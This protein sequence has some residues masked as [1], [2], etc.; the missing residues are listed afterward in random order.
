MKY[1]VNKGNH[2]ANLTLDRLQ[3]FTTKWDGT[4]N[5]N[6]N[7]WYEDDDIA[8]SGWNKLGGVS[9]FF[10]I[11][12]RSARL[13]FQP[14]DNLGEFTMAGYVYSNGIR[15]ENVIPI[16]IY[17]DKDYK[18]SIEYSDDRRSWDF[19]VK[20]MDWESVGLTFPS[21]EYSF[22]MSGCKPKGLTRKCYPYFGG[23]STAPQDVSAKI[24]Y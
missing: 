9:E 10:G 7:W 8:Y 12:N 18:V 23:K 21:R 2:Y 19:S 13:V 1:K 11:H 22:S 5:I 4:F 20:L 16:T 24:T 14:S 6:R 15:T 17:G 3:P